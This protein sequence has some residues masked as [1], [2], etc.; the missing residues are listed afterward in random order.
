M[1]IVTREYTVYP[2]EGGSS[3]KTVQFKVFADDDTKGV[4]EYLDNC[5]SGVFDF[6]K[7]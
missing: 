6:K 4:Q 5:K 3:Y 1:I 7:L 2:A